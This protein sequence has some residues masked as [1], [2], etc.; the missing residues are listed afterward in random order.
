MSKPITLATGHTL[1]VLSGLYTHPE[2]THPKKKKL[3]IGKGWNRRPTKLGMKIRAEFDVKVAAML[4]EL[5]ATPTPEAMY[6]WRIE[7]KHGPLGISTHGTW[8]ACRFEDS[9]AGKKF[10]GHWKWNHHYDEGAGDDEVASFRR[11]LESIL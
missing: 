2:L 8:I 4:R 10:C 3:S 1:T 9:D 5:R 7:T 6:M 11:Q